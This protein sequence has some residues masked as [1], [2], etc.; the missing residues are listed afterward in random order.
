MKPVRPEGNAL[1]G[2]RDVNEISLAFL[3]F[4]LHT[5]CLSAS[6]K[7]GLTYPS[8]SHQAVISYERVAA[9]IFLKLA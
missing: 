2:G 1:F 6:F 7:F 3:R 5:Q 8:G 4:L 9:K